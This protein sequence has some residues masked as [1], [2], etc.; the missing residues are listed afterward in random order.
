MERHALQTKYNSARINLLLAVVFTVVNMLLLAF[1]GDV[2]F[3]FSITVPYVISTVGMLLCGM[4]PDDFYADPMFDGMVFLDEGFFYITLAISVLVLAIYVLCWFFAKKKSVWLKVALVLFI[5]DTIFMISYYGLALDMIFDILFHAYVIWILV[6]GIMA[7]KKL[8]AMPAE[9]PII[10]AEFTDVSEE[11]TE[12][13]NS[14]ILRSADTMEKV[15]VLLDAEVNGHSIV[16]RRIKR[17]NELV[18]DGN[19]YDEYI[20]LAEYPHQLTAKINGHIYCAGMDNTSHCYIMVD[21]E[22]VKTKL[23]LI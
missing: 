8:K 10:E 22:T 7:D 3:L 4:L 5:L 14:A 21:G 18:I 16:Y 11:N 2:Y 19:V 20:A 17:T 1:G 23:R 6:S 9:E 12:S 15:K 13:E